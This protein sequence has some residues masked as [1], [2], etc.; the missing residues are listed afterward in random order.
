MFPFSNKQYMSHVYKKGW[1]GFKGMDSTETSY[2]K[3]T[4]IWENSISQCLQFGS[5]GIFSGNT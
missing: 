5:D 2:R 4:F 3:L 1:C